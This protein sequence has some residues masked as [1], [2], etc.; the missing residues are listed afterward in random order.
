MAE[1]AARH[2]NTMEAHHAP[3]WSRKHHVDGAHDR[4]SATSGSHGRRPH[5]ATK[6]KT[7]HAPIDNESW[8][9]ADA[10][11]ARLGRTESLSG[12]LFGS[13]FSAPER[14]R[15]VSPSALMPLQTERENSPSPPLKPVRR[16]LNCRV[17]PTVRARDSFM[18]EGRAESVGK[19]TKAS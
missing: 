9:H 17:G 5:N 18:Y 1:T 11:A 7:K 3:N 15:P 10:R 6:P 14:Q 16:T 2:V 12:Y 4:P 8:S 13:A 19:R